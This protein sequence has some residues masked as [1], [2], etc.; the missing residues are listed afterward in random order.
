[1]QF[2]GVDE[3]TITVTVIVERFGE[4]CSGPFCPHAAVPN[5]IAHKITK[6]IFFIPNSLL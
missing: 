1:M 2:N 5:T 3:L 6:L 4:A